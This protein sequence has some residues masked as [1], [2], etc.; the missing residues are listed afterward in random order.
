MWS[1]KETQR[2]VSLHVALFSNKDRIK[3]APHRRPAVWVTAR[4]CL[5]L[6]LQAARAGCALPPEALGG[7]SSLLGH[8]GPT[9]PPC[10]KRTVQVH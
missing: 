3:E 8:P 6:G 4:P 5:C 10:P 1:Y 7:S 2:G 9:C